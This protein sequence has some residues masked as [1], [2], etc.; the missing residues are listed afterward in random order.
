M[1]IVAVEIEGHVLINSFLVF[2]NL[3]QICKI[4][5]DNVHDAVQSSLHL[6]KNLCSL[7]ETCGDISRILSTTQHY[8]H[9]SEQPLL[10]TAVGS[11]TE[12]QSTAA[13]SISPPK[14]QPA[15]MTEIEMEDSPRVS[16]PEKP[17]VIEEIDI[18]LTGSDP[19]KHRSKI[20][21]SDT[22]P[23]PIKKGSK[24]ACNVS[25]SAGS[26]QIDPEC[27][28]RTTENY[29]VMMEE[30]GNEYSGKTDAAASGTER[31]TEKSEAGVIVL[32]D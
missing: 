15:D 27:L 9:I 4:L 8:P 21:D 30:T 18:D 25:A 26:S 6:K 7:E 14:Q 16:E 2:S 3:L 22:G 13:G 31:S 1:E 29:A 28:S 24:S 5:E 20:E 11:Q 23:D 19:L 17:A 12:S 32:D 10:G